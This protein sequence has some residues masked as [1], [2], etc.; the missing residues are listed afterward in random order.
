MDVLFFLGFVLTVVIGVAFLAFALKSLD[1]Q[2]QA[3]AQKDGKRIPGDIRSAKTIAAKMPA[4]FRTA[5][6]SQVPPAKRGFT[7]RLPMLHEIDQRHV[8]WALDQ[9]GGN[10]A[11]AAGLL[12]TSVRDFDLLVAQHCGN[13]LAA[14]RRTDA[15]PQE[16]ESRAASPGERDGIDDRLFVFIQNHIWAEQAVVREFIH[17]PSIDSLY[18]QGRP[19]LTMR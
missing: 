1:L 16:A 2:E 8:L 6:A 11:H 13:V 5:H 4:F 3:D 10:R 15:V 14:D 12:G 19:T 7:D 18:R 9:A 17:L